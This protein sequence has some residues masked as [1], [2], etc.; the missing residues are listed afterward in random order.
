MDVRKFRSRQV[1][2]GQVKWSPKLEN[3]EAFNAI[4]LCSDGGTATPT[5]YVSWHLFSHVFTLGLRSWSLL[6]FCLAAPN[7]SG[8]QEVAEDLCSETGSASSALLKIVKKLITFQKGCISF[9]PGLWWSRCKTKSHPYLW[10]GEDCRDWRSAERL[11]VKGR[12]SLKGMGGPQIRVFFPSV[13][14][15]E[16]PQFWD[17]PNYGTM[18]NASMSRSWRF[19][20]QE[21]CSSFG[22]ACNS[23]VRAHD[24][25][26]T[27]IV[28]AVA[29]RYHALCTTTPLMS[30]TSLASHCLPWNQQHSWNWCMEVSNMCRPPTFNHYLLTWKKKA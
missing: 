7:G 1:F 29:P 27:T 17:S 11:F 3:L 25:V 21:I 18:K 30:L 26:W 5:R 19:A 4:Q 13:H 20:S 10:S 16:D 24:S 9:S 6:R 15:L 14:H 23:R 2:L 22:F 28:V 12:Y 8:L